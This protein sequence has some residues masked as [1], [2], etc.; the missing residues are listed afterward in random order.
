LE[1]FSKEYNQ[2]GFVCTVEIDP[3]DDNKTA[4]QRFLAGGEVLAMLPCADNQMSIVWSCH[5]EK[6]LKLGKLEPENL[7]EKINETLKRKYESELSETIHNTLRF[8]L[9]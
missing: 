4:F 5:S 1:T 2:R 9:I 8:G 6:A 7:V 3:F